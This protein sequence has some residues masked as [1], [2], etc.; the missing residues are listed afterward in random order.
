MALILIIIIYGARDG[1]LA[2]L[3]YIELGIECTH[4]VDI[5]PNLVG[6]QSAEKWLKKLYGKLAV[7]ICTRLVPICP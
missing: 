2:E 3:E 4:N 6:G 1:L 7:E 5:R